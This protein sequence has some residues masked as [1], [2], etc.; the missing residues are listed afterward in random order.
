MF[1]TKTQIKL[2]NLYLIMST[3]RNQ[4]IRFDKKVTTERNENEKL[5][6]INYVKNI[7]I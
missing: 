2:N 4:S 7:I 6:H 5:L 3:Y 1:M